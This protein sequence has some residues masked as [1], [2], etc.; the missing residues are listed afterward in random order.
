MGS[1]AA[2]WDPCDG[3]EGATPCDSLTVARIAALAQA[4]LRRRASSATER[5][6]A[7]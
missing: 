2:L 3:S 7:P 1:D 6:G 5:E 4:T